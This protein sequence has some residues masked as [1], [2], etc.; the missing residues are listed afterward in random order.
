[1]IY[2]KKNLRCP[3]VQLKIH[4]IAF[5]AEQSGAELLA[6]ISF[7]IGDIHHTEEPHQL[8]GKGHFFMCV[9]PLGMGEKES[10]FSCLPFLLLYIFVLLS[11]IC[12]T[13][14]KLLSICTGH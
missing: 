12:I 4:R 9:L 13:A 6:V 7:G 1:M 2:K 11:R 14:V 8:L 3:A 5:T 10:G